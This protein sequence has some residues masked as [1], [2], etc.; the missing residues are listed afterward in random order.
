M[1]LKELLKKF[2]FFAL[3]IKT[4][5]KTNKLIIKTYKKNQYISSQTE[6]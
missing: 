1:I 4:K 2:F 5:K 6:G 3:Q